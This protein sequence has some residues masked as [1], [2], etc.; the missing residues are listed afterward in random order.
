MLLTTLTTQSQPLDG[1][2]AECYRRRLL[3]DPNRW[4]RTELNV[5]DGAHY[6]STLDVTS[7]HKPLAKA[8]TREFLA[9]L[10]AAAPTER[11]APLQ[12]GSEIR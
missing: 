2:R 5:I 7:I 9:V 8:F 11:Q 10:S 12:G 3:H 1:N 6:T 4:M